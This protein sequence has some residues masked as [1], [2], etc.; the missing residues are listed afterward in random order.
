MLLML[1]VQLKIEKELYNLMDPKVKQHSAQKKPVSTLKEW[2]Y[3]E[4]IYIIVYCKREC[5]V[6]VS[7]K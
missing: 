3:S 6:F 7:Y 2:L 5:I 1:P 4:Y